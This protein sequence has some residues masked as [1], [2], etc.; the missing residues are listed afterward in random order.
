MFVE[1]LSLLSLAVMRL[2]FLL[3]LLALM[4]VDFN[5]EHIKEQRTANDM[6][7]AMETQ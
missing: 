6:K 5:R 7:R 1:V 2:Y 3:L 4:F